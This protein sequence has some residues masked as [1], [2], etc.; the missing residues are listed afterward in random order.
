[1]GVTV[2]R[3]RESEL[4]LLVGLRGG[5]IVVVSSTLAEK[6]SEAVSVIVAVLVGEPLLVIVLVRVYD[7]V[8]VVV[9]VKVPLERVPL[10]DLAYVAEALSDSDG[11]PLSVR[12]PS[13]VIDADSLKVSLVV[14]VPVY[15]TVSELED[16]TDSEYVTDRVPVCDLVRELLRD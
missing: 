13:L 8:M 12:V 11:V 4:V 3:V 1:M 15:V 2:F 7:M 6:E 14:V 5:E 16:V 10:R 9:P